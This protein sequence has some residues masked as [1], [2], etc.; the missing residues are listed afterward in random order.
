MNRNET[1]EEKA[2]RKAKHERLMQF[3][4]KEYFDSGM[5]TFSGEDLF[6]CVFCNAEFLNE[7]DACNHHFEK[8]KGSRRPHKDGEVHYN[9]F[10]QRKA[11]NSGKDRN[12]FSNKRGF[13]E[14][15]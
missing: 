11:Y 12:R 6:T 13:K 14:V 3:I 1:P 10:K 4:L 2:A 7:N 15:S 8:H 9:E 5:G